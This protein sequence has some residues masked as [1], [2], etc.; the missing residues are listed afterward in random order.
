LIGTEMGRQRGARRQ[1]QG[2]CLGLATLSTVFVLGSVNSV[3]PC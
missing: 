2:V 3:P 1:S